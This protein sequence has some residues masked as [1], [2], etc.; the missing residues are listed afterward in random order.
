MIKLV[1]FQEELDRILTEEDVN[2]RDFKL[3]DFMT[4]MERNFNIPILR[5]EAW[6]EKNPAIIEMYR[7]ASDSRRF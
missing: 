1:D 7:L 6:E 2:V 3:A 4:R 5:N